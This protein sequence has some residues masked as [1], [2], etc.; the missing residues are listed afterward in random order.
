MGIHG[1]V[2]RRHQR[3]AQHSI[4]PENVRIRITGSQLRQEPRNRRLE[5]SQVRFMIA[6]ILIQPL[7]IDPAVRLILP[8]RG[9]EGSIIIRTQ[10]DYDHI[11]LPGGKIIRLM[12]TKPFILVSSQQAADLLVDVR[13]IALRIIIPTGEHPQPLCETTRYSASTAAAVSAV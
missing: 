3:E 10:V 2:D 6:S 8:F 12:R 13:N 9:V 7:F 11:R 4:H 5:S 1:T